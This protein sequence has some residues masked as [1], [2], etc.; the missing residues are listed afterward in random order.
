MDS[1]GDGNRL[2]PQVRTAGGA[3]IARQPEHANAAAV[4][5]QLAL[6]GIVRFRKLIGRD[7]I[8]LVKL[9]HSLL[10]R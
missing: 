7:E 1:V 10:L 8:I 3:A 4:R 9:A 5:Q 6:L 2:C